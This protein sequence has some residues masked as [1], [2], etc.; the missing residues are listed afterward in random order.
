[1]TRRVVALVC[2]CTALVGAVFASPA[3]AAED[4]ARVDR[5]L[6][7]SMPGVS[8]RDLDFEQLPNLEALLR[9]SALADL[10][11]RGVRRRPT[12]A[13]GYVTISA[14]A[15]AVGRTLDE[16][17]CFNGSEP[18]EEGTAREAMARRAGIAA[19]D[20]PDTAVV[21]LAQPAIIARND[22]LLFDAEPGALAGALATAG[23]HRA[24]IGNADEAEPTGTAGY[25]R[26]VG[27]SLADEHGV[28]PGGRVSQEL[29]ARDPLAPFGVRAAP[30]AYLDAFAE[31]WRDGS[32]V[33]VE[34]S[35]LVRFDAYRDVVA[36]DARADL[37]NELLRS[38]D[39]L[40]GSMLEQVDPERDAVMIVGPAHMNGTA[41]LT[42]ASLRAPGVEPGL[43]RS[44]Y[45]RHS[46]IVSIVDVGPTVLDLFGIERPDSMEG[47]PF[48]FSRTGGS[49]EDRIDWLIETD[50]AARFRDRMIPGVT[51]FYVV[52]TILLTVFAL[53]AF[54][55]YR[56]ALT[57]VQITALALLGF[58]PATYLAGLFPFHD[59]G[60]LAYWSF[61]L[62]VGTAIGL[63]AWFTTSRHGITT[64]IVAL[65]IVVAVLV[66][67]VVLGARLQFN[68]SLGYSPTVAGRFAGIGNLAYAQLA[69]GTLLLAGLV[70]ARVG[71]RR[72]AWIAVA[73][74]ATAIIVDG[75]PFFGS[76]VG[77]V[78][79]MVPAYAYTA[80]VLLGWRVRWRAVALYGA[81]ALVLIGLF[82][83]YDA[84]RPEED[85]THLGRLVHTTTD[86]GWDAFS[87]VL[88]RK[89]ASNL[90]VL[91]SS[92]WTVM[93]PIV[94]AG[95]AYLVYRSPGRLRGIVERIPP[96]RAALQGL[97]VLAALGFALNDSG[98][99]VP[100]VML[101]VVTPVLVVVTV[102]G[103]R[104]VVDPDADE[105]RELRELVRT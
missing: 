59:W 56:R 81:A 89:L 90:D 9:D 30:D 40:V 22:N 68:T 69:A 83:A 100:G 93:L 31:N 45:T 94:L 8:Y 43:L 101:G 39:R 2:A 44:A 26:M 103:E 32:V 105:E 55:R 87:T 15:R 50:E 98:I 29:L 24:V 77:G 18:F 71:G 88:Q 67:D 58:L 70:A 10:S 79:S 104:I 48:E 37:R 34:A 25:A 28:V 95:V 60:A 33:V 102:R 13:D 3:A 38:F 19:S 6:V 66:V 17:Q 80:T 63:V 75:A 73:L 1:V 57:A 91:F 42:M 86:G 36:A 52:A 65:G 51:T 27:L 54:V 53:V 76:D 20:I 49:F 11:V 82:A 41:R 7:L 5:L 23:V 74:L 72:G 12:V 62:V 96:L 47:R 21:C 16:G 99:A 85:Q 78:L 35:D 84:S 61:L 4:D 92:V 64:L 46:G 14:G 97:V